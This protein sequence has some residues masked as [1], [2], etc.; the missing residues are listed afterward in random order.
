MNSLLDTEKDID[1]FK[2]YKKSI[3]EGVSFFTNTPEEDFFVKVE[4]YLSN[5]KQWKK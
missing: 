2:K 4:T 1:M 3:E 5:W